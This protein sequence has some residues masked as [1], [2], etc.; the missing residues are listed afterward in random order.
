MFLS[1]YTP[2][3]V[4]PKILAAYSTAFA[5]AF[6]AFCNWFYFCFFVVNVLLSLIL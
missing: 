6:I 2:H 4:S 1:K 5:A 3:K